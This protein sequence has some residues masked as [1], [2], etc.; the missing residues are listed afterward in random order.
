MLTSA[1]DDVDTSAAETSHVSQIAS[2]DDVIIFEK[3]PGHVR[4]KYIDTH[5]TFSNPLFYDR[6]HLKRPFSLGQDDIV[7]HLT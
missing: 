5:L 2:V 1:K 3:D 7:D 6:L 4:L